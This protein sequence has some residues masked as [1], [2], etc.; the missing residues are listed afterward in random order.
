MMLVGFYVFYSMLRTAISVLI[1]AF[2]ISTLSAQS[3]IDDSYRWKT[4]T[5]SNVDLV[6]F[7]FDYTDFVCSDTIIGNVDYSKICRQG[8]LYSGYSAT[9][10]E[11]ESDVFDYKGAIRVEDKKWY[12]IEKDSIA[13]RILYDFNLNDTDS[14]VVGDL[15]FMQ[16]TLIDSILIDQDFH[17]VYQLQGTPVQLIEGIGWNT[18]LLFPV[19]RLLGVIDFSYL[20]CFHHNG[21]DYGLDLSYWQLIVGINMITEQACGP[22]STDVDDVAALDPILL[23]PNPSIDG[24]YV[25]SKHTISEI[26]LFDLNGSAIHRSYDSNI[27]FMDTSDLDAGIYFIRVLINNKQVI[28]RLIIQ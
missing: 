12:W 20:Q 14:I 28:Q 15:G 8:V 22:V 10:P 16:L 19:E 18:G 24:F 5:Y 6:Y 3:G 4:R 27:N 13:E 25:D 9:E 11:F 17:K 2:L 26:S 7:N 21:F 1:Y 23:Y